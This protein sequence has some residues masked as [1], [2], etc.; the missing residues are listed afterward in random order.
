[1]RKSVFGGRRTELFLGFDEK[2]LMGIREDPRG[3]TD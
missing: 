3:A 1:M 2:F